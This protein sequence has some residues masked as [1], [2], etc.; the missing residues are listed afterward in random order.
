MALFDSAVHNLTEQAVDAAWYK[1]QVVANNIANIAT[2]DY[3]ARN[4]EFSVMLN[5]E[6]TR[7]RGRNAA[8]R[9]AN[10]R[11]GRSSNVQGGLAVETTMA[12]G[13][14]QVLDGNNVDIE[15]ERAKLI[16]TQYQ[17]AALIDSLN[18]EY[19]KI[20]SAIRTS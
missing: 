7:G 10:G 6:M 12:T 9:T 20:R 19:S 16:D 4:V 11:S 14:R 3:K 18:S 2:P 13:T 1:Q 17:Y 5:D 8:S 15:A